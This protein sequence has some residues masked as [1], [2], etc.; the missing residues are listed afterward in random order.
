MHTLAPPCRCTPHRLGTVRGER[1]RETPR[2][3]SGVRSGGKIAAALISGPV[4]RRP[5]AEPT[6]PEL[7]VKA[8]QAITD[9]LRELSLLTE[10]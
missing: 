4:I 3:R 5:P 1:E 7:V 6:T 10:C 8:A 2:V 9:G